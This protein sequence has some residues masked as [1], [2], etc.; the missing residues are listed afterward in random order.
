[1]R[2]KLVEPGYAPTTRFADSS[3]VRVEDLIPEAY[4]AFAQPIFAGFANPTL[5]TKETDV[6]EAVWLAAGD[7]SGQLRF[8]A[9]ADAVA[10]ALGH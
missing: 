8:A 2:V 7:E 9:G 5:V 6:A 1:M 10:L 3:D 4:A